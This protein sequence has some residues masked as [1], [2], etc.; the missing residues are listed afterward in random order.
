MRKVIQISPVV[1]PDPSG[2]DPNDEGHD[3][4]YDDSMLFALCDDGS[5]WMLWEANDPDSKEESDWQR[6][7]SPPLT[8]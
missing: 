6:V 2:I 5:I 4:R 3:P 1:F 8:D 7:P